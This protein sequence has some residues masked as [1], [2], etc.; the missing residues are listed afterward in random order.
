V[1]QAVIAFS[2]NCSLMR[3]WQQKFEKLRSFAPQGPKRQ[4]RLPNSENCVADVSYSF[5]YV[6]VFLPLHFMLFL[7]LSLHYLLLFHILDIHASNILTGSKDPSE[8]HYTLDL[9]SRR[10]T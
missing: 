6:S 10:Q 7:L 3:N 4:V 9:I 5:T 2:S 8:V 1:T